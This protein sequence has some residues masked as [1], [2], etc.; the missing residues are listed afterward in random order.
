MAKRTNGEGTV[1]YD[2]RRQEYVGCIRYWS[3]DGEMHRKMFYSGKS[4]N[5]GDVTKKMNDWRLRHE[6]DYAETHRV[7]LEDGIKAWLETCKKPDLKPSSYDRIESTINCQIIPRI[8]WRYIT[9]LSDSI[10]Q[11]EVINAIIEEDKLSVSTAKKAYNALNEFLKYSVHKKAITSN[12]MAMMKAPKPSNTVELDS[13]SEYTVIGEKDKALSKE[14]TEKL[15]SI[16]Y[17]R[18]K[19][20]PQRRRYVNG[21]AVD[22]ILNTGLRMGEALA[23]QWSDVNWKKNTISVTK[24]LIRVKNRS[25]KGKKYKLI[26]QDKPKTEKSRRIVPLNKAAL[27]ALEDLKTAPGYR[28]EG[29]IIHNKDG[30]AVLPRT[31]EETLE[32]MCAAVGIRKIGVHALRHTYATRLFEKGVDIKIISELLGHSS[33]EI[34]YRIYVHV[35]DSLKEAAVEALDLD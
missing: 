7:K 12:P 27:A 6:S 13:F 8:G 20:A 22:L 11:S 31:L 5:K 29:F 26:L 23:L 34:T 35:I 14:E 18:W 32:N 30:A 24:N 25:G 21:G 17:T 1:Y 16:L 4:R 2:P 10:I 28:P 15:R 3:D 33:T 9:D 19:I